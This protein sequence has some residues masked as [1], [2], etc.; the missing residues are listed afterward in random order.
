MFGD[1]Q[2]DER[3]AVL[4]TLG[5]AFPDTSL[6]EVANEKKFPDIGTCLVV[7]SFRKRRPKS[8]DLDENRAGR[9]HR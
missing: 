9:Y 1:W 2:V 6:K 4:Y 3:I 8:Q 5:S 7:N